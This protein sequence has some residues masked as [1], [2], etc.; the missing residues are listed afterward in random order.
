MLALCAAHH[1]ILFYMLAA[2]TLVHAATTGS[3][4]D[5]VLLLDSS[6]SMKKTDSHMLRVS[7][8][9][10]FISL[11]GENDRVAV[12]S[13]SDNGYP[14]IGLTPTNTPHNRARLLSA[15]DKINSRGAY[16]NLYAALTKAQEM[17]QRS[18]M[19][20]RARYILLLTD[21]KMDT[22]NKKQDVTL[23]QKI[24]EELA[25]QIGK[26][27]V[28][29][30]TIAFTSDSDSN[31]MREVAGKTNG[32]FRIAQTD[33]DLPSLFVN[34]F[35]GSKKPDMLPINGGTFRI[36]SSIR[37]VTIVALKQKQGTQVALED[38]SGKRHVG[39]R[40][41]PGFRWLSAERFEM[42][43]VSQ[44]VAGLWKLVSDGGQSHAYIVT[45]M[46]L[47]TEV[48]REVSAGARPVAQAW[49]SREGKILVQKE[50]LSSTQ[51][52][53]ELVRPDGTVFN[54]PLLD[55]GESGDKLSADG[56]YSNQ[57]E[58]VMPGPYEI[59]L[60]AKNPT[61]E[62]KIVRGFTALPSTAA[63]AE[64]TDHNHPAVTDI[65]KAV[66]SPVMTAIEPMAVPDVHPAVSAQSASIE[67]PAIP[68][69]SKAGNDVSL[70]V[71]LAA[72]TLINLLVGGAA[73]GIYI[74]MRRKKSQSGLIR[75]MEPGLDNLDAVDS[76][77]ASEA[78]KS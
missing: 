2:G 3:G 45:D 8:A 66:E 50:I 60:M 14:V 68:S 62:R 71:V 52:S 31:L 73:F 47:E 32:Q 29:I 39:A 42:V 46:K 65:A 26:Q 18:S 36:D 44:P 67:P 17:L 13:F 23:T 69:H 53:V 24:M 28:S 77:S 4:I 41:E 16:T 15:A 5:A 78:E 38:P 55:N 25:P 61:F 19:D 34:F 22:G 58:A 21:G 12:I 72:F 33:K 7:A 20:G 54:L 57:S 63:R 48:D 37:E 1:A 75:F 76:P 56:I 49:L 51:F 59:R 70:W 40:D 9:K 6:G 43:T 64:T 10:L 30:Y 74:W 11:L 35:E 27:G